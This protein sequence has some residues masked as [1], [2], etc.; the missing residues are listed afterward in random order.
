M[1][2]RV[3]AQVEGAILY[4]L[5]AALQGAITIKNSVVEQSNSH[6]FPLLTME[7]MPVVDVHIV[8][9]T[10]LPTGTGE[11]GTPPIA[12]AVTNALFA[13]TGKRVRKLP[14]GTVT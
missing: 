12:P 11:L 5:T 4:G 6:D 3:A 14:I 10:A 2:L 8:R 1:A 7:Q 9:S 13:L